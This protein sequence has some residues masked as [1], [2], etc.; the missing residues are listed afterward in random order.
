[1]PQQ[2]YD[3]GLADVAI[4]NALRELFTAQ[5]HGHH[6]KRVNVLNDLLAAEAEIVKVRRALV[7]GLCSRSRGRADEE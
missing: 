7:S 2:T 5:R 3:W 1:M 4:G 6:R